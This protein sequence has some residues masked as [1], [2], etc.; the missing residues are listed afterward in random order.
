MSNATCSPGHRQAGAPMINI[1]S[2]LRTA[3][4][5]CKNVSLQC[6][7][8][9]TVLHIQSVCSQICVYIHTYCSQYEDLVGQRNKRKLG[10]QWMQR[11][12]LSTRFT[13]WSALVQWMARLRFE[14][15]TF[16]MQTKMHDF[17][18]PHWF[19]PLLCDV[20]QRWLV[21]CYRRFGI[22]FRPNIR[23]PSRTKPLKMG[24]IGCHKTSV[25]KTNQRC[26]T[27]RKVEDRKLLSVSLPRLFR[28]LRYAQKDTAYRNERFEH[29]TTRF[30]RSKAPK[31]LCD[32]RL[33]SLSQS[34]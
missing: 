16:Q 33:V 30:K 31:H 14:I 17:R 25:T 12:I 20:T 28:Y 10:Q 22:S 4:D 2:T 11:V 9:A 18:F 23:G 1:Q 5:L 13:V 29:S 8:V 3:P 21:V 27:S 7:L 15:L 26:V 34:R 32:Q 24:P 19:S 6:Y